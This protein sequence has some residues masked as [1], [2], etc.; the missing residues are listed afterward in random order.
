MAWQC[1]LEQPRVIVRVQVGDPQNNPQPGKPKEFGLGVVFSLN[2]YYLH[3]EADL[4]LPNGR[5]KGKI[6]TPGYI[7]KTVPLNSIMEFLM[8][9]VI[10]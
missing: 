6:T 4:E 9:G 3:T 8:Y 1:V 10:K 2:Y 7:T 5:I